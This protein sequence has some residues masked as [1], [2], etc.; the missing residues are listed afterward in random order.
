VTAVRRGRVLH[1]PTVPFGWLDG[2]AGLNRLIGVLWLARILDEQPVA[3]IRDEVRS[4]YDEFYGVRLT[5]A[6]IERLLGGA[7]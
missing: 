7:P 5:D 4:F 1:A 2:P 6:Q 3:R